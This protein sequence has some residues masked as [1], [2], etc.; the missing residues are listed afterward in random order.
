MLKIYTTIRLQFINNLCFMDYI[1]I[2]GARTNN[3]KN[4][5]IK[6]PKEQLTVITGLSGSGKSSLAF[7]TIYAE[8]HRRYV[9]NLSSYAKQV[10]GVLNKPDIDSADGL[11]PAIA[12]DQKTIAQSPRS[13]VGTLTEIYDYL[14]L[15]FARAG[16]PKCPYCK[17]QLA[18]QERRAIFESVRSIITSSHNNDEVTI[19]AP[20]LHK[21][22]GKKRIEEA[23]K[24]VN[25]TKFSLLRHNGVTVA[26]AKF[27]EEKLYDD[28]AHTLEVVL[29]QAEPAKEQKDSYTRKI[30]AQLDKALTYGGGR[31][32]LIAG[33]KEHNFSQ[34]YTCPTCATVFPEINP[35]LFSF[36]SPHGACAV[37]HGLGRK[38]YIEPNLVIPNQQLTLAEGAI[39][40]WSR[41]A[42]QTSWYEKTLSELA[43]R[44]NFSIDTPI[45]HLTD[46]E[47]CYVLYGDGVF[48]GVV[49]NLE[50]RYTETDSE[51]LRA[52]IEKYMIEKI[53]PACNGKRLREEALNIFIDGKNIADI[54]DFSVEKLSYFLNSVKISKEKEPITSPIIFE[55]KSR[56]KNLS[57]VGLSYLSL[58]RQADSLAGGEAQRI[59]LATQLNGALSGI[60]YVLDEPSIGLHPSDIA[61]LINTLN[62]LKQRGNTLIVVE[63]DGEIMKAA[64]YII[65]IGPLAGERGGKVVAQGTYTQLKK[66]NSLTAQYLSGRKKIPVPPKRR[67]VSEKKSIKVEGATAFNLRNINVSLPLGGLICITGVSGS[68]KSTLV[69]EILGKKVAQYF[70][71]AQA[72]PGEHKQI[73]GL[74]QLNKAINI[75]QSPIGRTPRSNLVTYTGIFSAI[76]TLFAAQP[77]ARLRGFSASHF[78]FNLKGGRCEACHGD[79]SIK[80]EM[81]FLPDVYVVCE[82]CGG[83]R[84]NNDALEIYVRDKNIADV[85]NMTVDVAAQFFADEPNIVDKLKVLQ[86][87]GLGYVPLGQSATTLSGGE[88]QRIKLATELSRADTGRTLY[89]LDEPTTGLHFEDVAMLLNVL[90]QLANK[91][92]TVLVI[93]HNLDVIKSA[94]W[95]VDV[96]PGGGDKGGKI[97]ASGP[98][99][100]VANVK[101]SLTGNF[102][103]KALTVK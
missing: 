83:K 102:I 37:C 4:V 92:N 34:N 3:L 41:M 71:R 43:T 2:K 74:N 32:T 72:K 24:R 39:R 61:M 58:N 64:D 46:Q 87:V 44:N 91:G 97:V 40:P 75:D 38:K 95:V 54:T 7:D 30:L 49:N 89:I 94:D 67:Q 33:K 69:Y 20:L 80:V 99:E 23:I 52:E 11:I 85:L 82:T 57:E 31:A 13:T 45:A 96:G 29:Y 36:N 26:R 79:G 76:R 100:Q 48:E 60:L 19:L 14:R 59:R 63:H 77:E 70:H 21:E 86:A 78:S 73:L 22:A 17:K 42:N 35:K 10:L 25:A 101:E 56:L 84:Y 68:G 5:D 12:I 9:E 55:I 88:A 15:A 16:V 53:C 65:D 62:K 50:R 90:Q 28:K 81:H 51:Y 66:A 18:K 103:K 93:E 8:G 1:T 98:P 6:I 27:N 47:K